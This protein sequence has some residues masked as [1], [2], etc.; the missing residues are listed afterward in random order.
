MNGEAASKNEER[1]DETGQKIK[2]EKR[3]K[4]EKKEK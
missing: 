2:K 1:K 3:M 4:Q